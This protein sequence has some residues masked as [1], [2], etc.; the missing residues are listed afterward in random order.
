MDR[1]NA[2]AASRKFGISLPAWVFLVAFA[3][4]LATARNILTDQDPYWHIA[5][6]RWI[7]AHGAVPHQDVFSSSMA[8]APWV[9]HEWLSE[10]IMAA[11]Y[12]QLGWAG[13]VVG[14]AIV[15]A[16]TLA[17]LVALLRRYFPPSAALV[18]TL[19]AFGLCAAHL[20]ARPHVFGLLLLVLWLGVLV[21]AR[22]EERAPAPAF[23]LLMV[24]WANLH[25][26]FVVGLVLAALLAGE[27]LFEAPDRPSLLRAARGWGLFGGLALLAAV[28]TPSG[29]SG[30]LLTFDFMRMPFALSTINEWKSPD[31]QDLQPLEI[32]L[33]LAILGTLSTG[34][35]LPVTRIAML[36]LLLHE[37]LS[38]RR[39]AEILGLA[40]PLLLAP[41]LAIRLRATGTA[42]LD[43]ALA[44]ATHAS[45]PLGLA[46][47]GMAIAVAA[48]AVLRSGISNDSDRFAPSAA[49]QF[50]KDHQLTGSVFNDYEFGGYLIFSGIAP[51]VDGR[52]DM[53]GD[54]FLKRAATPSELPALLAQYA[55]AW[56]LLDPRD[57]RVVLLDHLP[58]WRRLYTDDIAVVHVRSQA[59]GAGSDSPVL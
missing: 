56:T 59:A 41:A 2:A 55:V 27:A 9:P 46:L 51:F 34:V 17:F 43:R 28:A 29:L 44:A 50:A 12:D 23:A 57:A 54:A 11:T 49:V 39:F 1:V 52:A 4:T 10:V 26:G 36:L 24:L 21:R 6:G 31:F 37:A 48:T 20:H 19:G 30:L 3:A 32:W 22:H 15:F 16:A 8:G 38:H 42:R 13:L 45:R 14:T 7:I 58:G 53:Y 25:G 5:A 40:T 35:R 33:L 47:A 18:A